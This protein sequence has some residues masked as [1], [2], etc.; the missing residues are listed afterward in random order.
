[1]L[2]HLRSNYYKSVAETRH[3]Q[4]TSYECMGWLY[5]IYEWCWFI[6]IN[7]HL[8]YMLSRLQNHPLL[9]FHKLK[10]LMTA[11]LW[12]HYITK[13]VYTVFQTAEKQPSCSVLPWHLE[14]QQSKIQPSDQ[15][16]HAPPTK[17]SWSYF[18]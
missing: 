7:A 11:I 4:N 17:E 14:D 1:M 9:F 5:K 2:T 13:K 15:Q 6:T 16:V 8:S 18:Q 12:S 10:I 3:T